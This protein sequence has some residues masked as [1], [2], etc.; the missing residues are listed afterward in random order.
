MLFAG[1]LFFREFRL[2]RFNKRWSVVPSSIFSDA[3]DGAKENIFKYIDG[4]KEIEASSF[5][6][7]SYV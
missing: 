2:G 7:V 6:I 1:H 4:V 5:G 3:V